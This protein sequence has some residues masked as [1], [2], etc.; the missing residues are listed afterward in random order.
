[1][2]RTS[3]GTELALGGRISGR[4]VT[5]RPVEESDAPLIQRWM[6]HPEVWR[7]MDYERP[8]S[9]ADVL[10]DIRAGRQEGQ[11]FT[12]LVDE[13]PIGRIGLNRFRRR[14]RICSLYMFIG[15]PAYWGQGYARDSVMAL[16]SYAFD[17]SDLHQVE[18]WSLADNVRAIPMYEGCGFVQEARLRERSWKQGTWVDHVVMVV[19][20][21]EFA[22][23]RERWESRASSRGRRPSRPRPGPIRRA[24]GIVTQ[25]EQ[26][27]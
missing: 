20:R 11:P 10:D 27:A 12:I 16:L 23:A 21:E 1:M 2:E 13:R 19:N 8:V 3:E 24:P 9:L 4:K 18:L 6:N 5:L 17:R 25:D 7:Y 14:D 26:G 15:E 22:A